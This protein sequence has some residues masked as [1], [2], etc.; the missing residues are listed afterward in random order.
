MKYTLIP[1]ICFLFV[2][3]LQAQELKLSEAPENYQLYPRNEKDSAQ[4]VLSGSISDSDYK[5]LE[6]ITYKDGQLLERKKEDIQFKK[7]G[8][9]KFSVSQPILAGLFQYKFELNLINAHGKKMLFSADSVVCGD[10]Y[11]ITGQSNSHAS[12]SDSKFSSPYC[13]SFGVKTGYNPYTEEHKKHRWGRA[14]GDSPNLEGV[15]GWFTDNPFG[16]GV[17]GMHL[18]QKIIEANQMPVCF[19]NGGSGSSSIEQ[20]MPSDFQADLNTSFGRLIYRVNEAG[21]THGIKAIL[22]HQGESNTNKDYAKYKNN[23]DILYHAWKA[24]FPSLQKV[25][26]FQLHPGCGSEFQSELRNLQVNIANSYDD[27]EIM[28]TMGLPGHDGCHYTHEGYVAM[29]ESIYPLLARDSYGK[30]PSKSITPP[31]VIRAYIS[32]ADNTEI[33]LEFDQDIVWSNEQSVNGKTYSLKDYIYINGKS[34]LIN[35]GN[36]HGN[37]VYLKLKEAGNYFQV[38]YLPGHFYEG[39]DICYEG[40]WIMGTNGIG[41]LS[42]DRT[43]F[44]TFGTDYNKIPV[45]MQLFPRDDN[46]KAIVPV[47]GVVWTKGFDKA[48][49]RLYREGEL[50]NTKEMDLVYSKG[51]ASFSFS[52][53]IKAE[54][55][56]YSIEMGFM[57][58]GKFFSDR[59]VHNIVCGDVYL[60]NGQSNSHPSREAAIYKNEYCRS[61]GSNTNYDAYNPADTTWG[62]AAGDVSQQYH[63]SAW[64]IKLMEQIV[65]QYK[66]P[67]CIING[68]SGGSNIAYNVPIDNKTDLSS[69]YNRLLY[70]AKKAGVQKAV[71]AILWHQGESD[72]NEDR[73]GDYDKNFKTLYTAW[74]SDFP[75]IEK[76]FVFQIHPGCGGE[77]QSEIREI[78]RKFKE[79]YND[80][81]VMSTLGLPGHDGCHYTYEGYNKMGDWIF[82]LVARAFYDPETGR[83]ADS[84]NITKAYYTKPGK[85]ICLVFD[86][87][88]TW[89]ENAY[90]GHLLKDQFYVDG[91]NKIVE[92]GYADGNKVFLKL[93]EKYKGESITYLPGHFYEGT[94]ICYQGPWIFGENKI[95]AL[96]FMDFQINAKP[97][98]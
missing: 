91:T 4:V 70:R 51:K 30:K 80:V 74:K 86:R 47:D 58:N 12:S 43:R 57:A 76:V 1:I 79:K 22:W 64:G 75:A 52:P 24:N 97:N 65:E 60:I 34:G 49:C 14:T 84:P 16:V 81:E 77:R 66:I 48:V 68:G 15:G 85:E 3:V 18:A 90:E 38:T 46:D 7:N 69:T 61:F 44:D 25:Y 88:L 11:I 62:L 8:S 17:W 36:S 59:K 54:L 6:L 87:G 33:C 21:L 98:K 32:N 19:I 67:V 31:K 23:F 26:M 5:Q 94:D 28:S 63:V 27:V 96:S 83:D 37:K 20:N 92:S 41:A 78:Q 89:D 39:T 10:A 56:E 72:S 9:A 73:Y 71:K 53:E 13:R 95:G 42:F 82:P 29:A 55:A 35:E 40:P 50:V 93:N 45:A 2:N